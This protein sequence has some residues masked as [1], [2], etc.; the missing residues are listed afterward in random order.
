MFK[1]HLSIGFILMSLVVFTGAGHKF[2]VSITQIDVN[3]QSHKLE[4]S[5]RIF[6]DDLDASI[7]DETGQNLRLGSGREHPK[8]DSLLMDYLLPRLNFKQGGSVVEYAFIG[9]EVEADVTWIYLESRKEI[10][11]SEPLTIRNGL[12]L[13]LFPDQK[14]LV[15][16]KVNKQTISRIHTKS[17]TE[18]ST[19]LE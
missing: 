1:K 11:T 18:F 4:I 17:H 3:T 2:Y 7:L 15:N 16:V 6:S 19:D 14:N 10:S 8:S 5:A 13:E 9:K 12:L